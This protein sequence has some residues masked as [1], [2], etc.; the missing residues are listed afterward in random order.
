MGLTVH[1]DPE[2]TRSP[3]AQEVRQL[4]ET[5]RQFTRTFRSRKSGRSRNS[6]GRNTRLGTGRTMQTAGSKSNR[7]GH[8]NR[9]RRPLHGASPAISSLSR[10]CQVRVR[11]CKLR[12]LPVPDV[13][14]PQKQNNDTKLK[15][16]RWHSFCKT[17]YASDPRCGGVENFLRCHLCVVKLL[18]FPQS[19]PAWRW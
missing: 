12:L 9:G 18:D 10:P 4:V 15:G 3:L 8:I 19:R 14:D 17:Q 2:N 16:W 1:Y 11:T 5:I 6:W 7:V 13:V